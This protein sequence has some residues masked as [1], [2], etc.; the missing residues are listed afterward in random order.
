MSL[1]NEN[2]SL[3]L[4]IVKYSRIGLYKVWIYILYATIVNDF[5]IA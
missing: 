3:A 5:T 1:N 4:E 2:V